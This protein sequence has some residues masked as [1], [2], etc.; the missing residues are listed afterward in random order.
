MSYTGRAFTTALRTYFC[1]G[2]ILT[3]I[4]TR[5]NCPF[6]PVSLVLP[7][8]QYF[9]LFLLEIVKLLKPSFLLFISLSQVAAA[10]P[11]TSF[12]KQAASSVAEPCAVRGTHLVFV[13]CCSLS[14]ER[15]ED[16]FSGSIFT[17]LRNVS[18]EVT[19]VDEKRKAGRPAL[20]DTAICFLLLKVDQPHRERH[21]R[22]P[23][24]MPCA[25][26]S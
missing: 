15:R 5:F 26:T 6:I 7:T 10:L 20:L 25:P 17:A 9:L 21:P 12:C 22:P 14:H 8:G 13:N 19:T 3:T 2:D 4:Q 23:A 24:P 1:M 16:R 11:H 18:S